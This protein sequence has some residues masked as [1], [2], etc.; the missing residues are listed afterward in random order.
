MAN[1]AAVSSHIRLYIDEH[2]WRRLAS[3][4][5]ERGFDAINVYDVGRAGLPDEEQWIFAAAQKRAILTFDKDEGRFINLAVEWFY[6]GKT[7]YGLVISRQLE[8]GELLR[9][10][11][12]LLNSITADEL[13]NTIRFLEDFK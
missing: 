1:S 6:A 8:R 10:V 5:R 13:T 12:N 11:L 7:H 9:R 4:L 3:E 2:I